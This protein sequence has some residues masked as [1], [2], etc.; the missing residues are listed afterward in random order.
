MYYAQ[1]LDSSTVMGRFRRYCPECATSISSSVTILKLL[2]S[3]TYIKNQRVF[4]QPLRGVNFIHQISLPCLA[5]ENE[6]CYDYL[7]VKPMTFAL[8]INDPT[9]CCTTN[10]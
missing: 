5:F 2:F 8:I 9:V 1:T 6:I 4:T 7:K 10:F 3:M